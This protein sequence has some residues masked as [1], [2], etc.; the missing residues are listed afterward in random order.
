MNM[1]H[2]AADMQLK[3]ALPGTSLYDEFEK[4]VGLATRR[5]WSS[6]DHRRAPDASRWQAGRPLSAVSSREDNRWSPAP[7]SRACSPPAAAAPPRRAL[8][9]TCQ[10]DS[11]VQEGDQRGQQG[12]CVY[13]ASAREMGPVAMLFK[14]YSRRAERCPLYDRDAMVNFFTCGRGGDAPTPKWLLDHWGYI[15][16][17]PGVMTHNEL[18][19]FLQD[20]GVVPRLVSRT[21][22]A[23]A[24]KAAS[25]RICK[26]PSG[27]NHPS[28]I[29]FM[30]YLD[31]MVRLAVLA[32]S[33]DPARESQYTTARSKV[34]AFMEDLDIIGT[35]TSKLKN[36]LDAL[37]RLARD[38]AQNCAARKW[39]HITLGSP[40][41]G[42]AGRG[43]GARPLPLDLLSA[44]MRHDVKTLEADQPRW[45]EFASPAIDMGVVPLG[46][47][48][49]YRIVVRNRSRNKRA[50]QIQSA[51]LPFATLSYSEHPLAPGLPRVVDIVATFEKAGEWLGTVSIA[52]SDHVAHDR[53]T[54][55]RSVTATGAGAGVRDLGGFEEHYP[56]PVYARA[57]PLGG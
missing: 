37:A 13:P 22:A 31:C 1:A 14:W 49:R 32:F 2:S 10:F 7:S 48:R 36:R 8:E 25:E 21:S 50:V 33:G 41:P 23:A 11:N 20:F 39:D 43:L 3:S 42:A 53:R 34:E 29:C 35:N 15:L 55:A 45:V 52:G 12:K 56:I 4:R 28:E 24:F 17:V 18:M 38:R 46:E 44:L 30:E 5:S 40:A 16:G 47:T 9:V 27:N 54:Y 51:N 26:K 19:A 57:A 6:L